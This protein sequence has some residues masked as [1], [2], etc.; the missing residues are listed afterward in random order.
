MEMQG[1]RVQG[2]KGPRHNTTKTTITTTG[3]WW[4]GGS[5]KVVSSNQITTHSGTGE[6]ET[7]NINVVGR[8]NI[9][10]NYFA[11]SPFWFLL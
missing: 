4:H 9:W 7:Q 5:E 3:F 2:H 6:K 1:T 11:L 8:K 10:T